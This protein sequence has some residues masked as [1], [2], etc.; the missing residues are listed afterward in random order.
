M[1]KKPGTDDL[2]KMN[3][4]NGQINNKNK[5]LQ[6]R[7]DKVEKSLQVAQ[8]IKYINTKLGFQTTNI[9]KN[10]EEQMTT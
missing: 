1:N 8:L 2:R 7:I 10:Y 3:M 9:H 6:E 5:T 4:I